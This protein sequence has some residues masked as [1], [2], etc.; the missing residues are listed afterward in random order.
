MSLY[1]IGCIVAPLAILSLTSMASAQTTTTTTTV[2]T[3]REP[4][5]LSPQQ[6]VTIYRTVKRESAA[7]VPPRNFAVRRGEVVPPVVVLNPLPDSVYADAPELR[8]YR[9]FYVNNQLVLVDPVTSEVVDIIQ[10]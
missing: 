10:D 6:R 4:L 2:E 9:Y 7:A 3:R 5:I 8:P 1:R